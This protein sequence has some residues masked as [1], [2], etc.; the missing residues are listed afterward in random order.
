[1]KRRWKLVIALLIAVGVIA[2]LLIAYLQMSK[3]REK[4]GETEKV[5]AAK[6]RVRLGT[7]GEAIL[8]LDAETQKRIALR[9][10]PVS[11]A[12][13]DPELK[14][15]GRVLDPAPLASLAADLD[16][17]RTALAASQ[18]E[19]ERLKSLNEQK[20]A[21]DRALQVAEVTTRREQIQTEA[22]HAQLV[23]TWGKAIAEQPDLTAFVHSLISLGSVVVRIDLPAGE[24]LSAVPVSARVFT[25]NAESNAISAEFL[26]PAPN[27][28]PQTQGQG[29]LFFVKTNPT[30]LVPGTA[31]EGYL[32]LPGENLNGFIIPDSAV[33][34]FADQGWIYLQTGQETFTRQKISLD[35]PQESGWFVQEGINT[36]ARV[37]V[38]GAQALLSE[39]Q[40]YQIK[41][42]D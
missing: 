19:F 15:Y 33:V 22:L 37:V 21:S 1:M 17:A 16:S 40:K 7:N 23:L 36:N 9:V 6:S 35:H 39:E 30:R 2:G 4:E 18:K 29:L 3:E 34:R 28:D 41:M 5:V 11:P 13:M 42:L 10:E 31:V 24:V 12:R 8:T 27:I 32:R 25:S 38:S 20:N 14:G 26:G